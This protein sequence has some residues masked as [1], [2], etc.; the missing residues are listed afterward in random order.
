M[1]YGR[2]GWRESCEICHAVKEEKIFLVN[3]R[4][5]LSSWFNSVVKSTPE[6]ESALKRLSSSM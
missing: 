1:V 3:S 2:I 5:F 4:F 6:L